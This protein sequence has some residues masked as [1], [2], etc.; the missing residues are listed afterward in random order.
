MMPLKILNSLVQETLEPVQQ[1][2]P[3]KTLLVVH[4]YYYHH[5]LY[6]EAPEVWMLR[7]H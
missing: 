1:Y 3:N 5:H 2:T 6:P 4:F 7:K